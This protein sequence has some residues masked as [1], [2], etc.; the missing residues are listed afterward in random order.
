MTV[1]LAPSST[2]TSE[3][4]KTRPLVPVAL[5]RASTGSSTS[6]PRGTYTNRPPSQRAALRASGR[7]PKPI[8]PYRRSRTSASCSTRAAPSSATITPSGSAPRTGAE[9]A[10]SIS[11]SCAARSPRT[12]PGCAEAP[13]ASG[14][15][16][17]RPRSIGGVKR[18]ASSSPVS[19]G[20]EERDAAAASRT[21]VAQVG[22]SANRALHLQ[23][24]QP[25]E[26]D[27]VLHRQLLGDRL[28]EAA[29][30]IAIASSSE[31]PRLMR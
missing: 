4:P 16:P 10:P 24:D 5:S 20:S 28:D 12:M 30:I 27:R 15:D 8:R 25:V 1:A 23:L 18:Q 3:R 21:S 7:S 17:D 19:S 2:T 11:S 6:T 13:G 26:L 29:T 9:G 31:S 14:S 22:C